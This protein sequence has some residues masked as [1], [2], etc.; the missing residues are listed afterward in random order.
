MVCIGVQFVIDGFTAILQDP[1]FWS[2]LS[3]AV[4]GR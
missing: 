4:A 2:G 1:G 3:R